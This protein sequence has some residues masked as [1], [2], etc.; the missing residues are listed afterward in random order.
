MNFFDQVHETQITR[1]YPQPRI[2]TRRSVPLYRRL[3]PLDPP[4]ERAPN[5]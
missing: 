4:H 3:F 5:G 2:A 1:L